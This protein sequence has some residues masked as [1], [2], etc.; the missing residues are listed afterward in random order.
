MMY[1]TEEEEYAVICDCC[2][3][4]VGTIYKNGRVYHSKPCVLTLKEVAGKKRKLNLCFICKDRIEE[5]IN[6]IKEDR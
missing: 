5:F 6:K 4:D 3:N 1:F 2:G